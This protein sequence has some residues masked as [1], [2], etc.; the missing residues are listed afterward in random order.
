MQADLKIE[1]WDLDRLKKWDKN[2]RSISKNGLKRLVEQI[3]RLGQ[4]KPLIVTEDGTIIGGNMRFEAFKEIGLKQVYVSIVSPKDEDEMFE[5][6]LSDNDPAGFYDDDL[7]ANILPTF[8][9]DFSLYSVNMRE[10]TSLKSISDISLNAQEDEA[11]ELDEKNPPV[12]QRGEVYQLGRHRLMCGDSTS[13]EDVGK[14]MGEDKAHMIFTDPPYMV[15]YHSPKGLSYDSAKFGNSGTIFNDNLSDLDALQFYIDVLKNLYTFTHDTVT[16][17]WWFANKQNLINRISWEETGWHMSQII[18]WLK[19]SMVFSRGQD[20]HRM[21]EPCMLGWKKK[22]THFRNRSVSKMTDVFNLEF[23]DF[24]LMLDVWYQRRDN[25]AD[26]VHPTQKPVRLAERA[27]KK[28]S[29]SEDIVIDLFGGS[30]S[31]LIACQ[32]MNRTARLMELDPKYCDVIRK[33]Y[34]NLIGRGDEWQEIT[35]A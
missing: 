33:R 6:A 18:I 8:D 2:P 3:R 13:A 26:Y 22:K 32:Q 11:P 27:I 23:E 4:Y 9:I 14:L 17:Y 28:S 15:D 30:G 25:T 34:C 7:L 31:T 20:Y 35:K 19:N 10:A 29:K 24:E 12:S 21:Y 5:Y 16:L 1:L